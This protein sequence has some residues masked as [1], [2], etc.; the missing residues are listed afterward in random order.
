MILF[1]MKKDKKEM[2]T[3]CKK[4]GAGLAIPAGLFVGMG[5]GLIFDNF[6]AWLFIGLGIGFIAALVLKFVFKE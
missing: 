3:F 4:T 6:I 5:I 1:K 2:K